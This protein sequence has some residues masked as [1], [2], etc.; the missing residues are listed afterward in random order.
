MKKEIDPILKAKKFGKT[1][2][3]AFLVFA[4][5]LLWR[6]KSIWIYSVGLSLF[7]LFFSFVLPVFLIPIERRWMKVGH[8]LGWINTRI[9]LAILFFTVLTPIRF[10]LWLFRKDLLDQKIDSSKTSYWALRE[11]GA[12]DP[13]QY[14]RLY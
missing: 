7:F 8:T 14:E 12:I 13:K 10:F 9:I 3:W 11:A 4:G 2:F 5:L 6:G 1:L